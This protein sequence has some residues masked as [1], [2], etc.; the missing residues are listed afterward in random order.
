MRWL[1]SSTVA[2]AVVLSVVPAV[3]RA[4][5]ACVPGQQVACP[6]G[7]GTHSVQVCNPN[8]TG[9]EPCSCQARVECTTD[10]DC[11]GDRICEAGTCADQRPVAPPPAPPAPPPVLP[12]PAPTGAVGSMIIE[13]EPGTA[14]LSGGQIGRVPGRFDDLPLGD[15]ELRV[16]F[17]AGGNRKV[18]VLVTQ[19]PPL[20]MSV[21]PTAARAAARQREGLRFGVTAGGGLGYLF[22]GALRYQGEAGFVLNL[23][24]SPAV[25]L[26]SG[27]ELTFAGYGD[28]ANY[29]FEAVAPIQAQ[30]YL[31]SV[32]TMMVGGAVGFAATERVARVKTGPVVGPVASLVGLRFGELRQ[33]E[34]ALNHKFRIELGDEKSRSLVH[35]VDFTYLFL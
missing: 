11:T 10:I 1:S 34:V 22:A 32:Y 30:F 29:T 19:G 23:G 18:R 35:T 25:D 27:V 14:Y 7:D 15:H 12:T 6:C 3:A 16:D 8:G 17:D 21:E 13:S 20:Q 2:V 5:S 24:L 9:Y 31:G 28:K 26:R 33:L 4:Q